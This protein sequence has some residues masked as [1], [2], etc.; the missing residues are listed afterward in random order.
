MAGKAKSD[1][2]EGQSDKSG[3]ASVKGGRAS[4]LRKAPY[5]KDKN[6]SRQEWEYNNS[7]KD[8]K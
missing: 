6:T 4:R 2:Y 8:K 1:D 3:K 5:V 7:T